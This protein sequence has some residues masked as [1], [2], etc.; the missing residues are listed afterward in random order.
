M[1]YL[2]PGGQH[3]EEPQA[4]S[5]VQ[6]PRP[7]LAP[8]LSRMVGR[9][10]GEPQYN[11]STESNSHSS[12]D[13]LAQNEMTVTVNDNIILINHT[14]VFFTAEKEQE[15]NINKTSFPYDPGGDSIVRMTEHM[16]PAI[17]KDYSLMSKLAGMENLHTYRDIRYTPYDR[18]KGAAKAM[19]LITS[20]YVGMEVDH[21]PDQVQGGVNGTASHKQMLGSQNKNIVLEDICEGLEGCTSY[22]QEV[23]AVY[24]NIV[25]AV[26]QQKR[27][28]TASDQEAPC[29]EEEWHESFED[30]QQAK[31]LDSHL[32]SLDL[33]TKRVL[34]MFVLTLNICS[35]QVWS[36]TYRTKPG[37]KLTMPYMDKKVVPSKPAGTSHVCLFPD[38]SGRSQHA[39]YTIMRDQDKSGQGYFK[40]A[41]PAV[42]PCLVFQMSGMINFSLLREYLFTEPNMDQFQFRLGN[43]RA[44]VGVGSVEL[45]LTKPWIDEYQILARYHTNTPCWAGNFTKPGVGTD[46]DF[47]IDI[48]LQLFMKA[49]L[50]PALTSRNI[51]CKKY[52]G[53]GNH[54]PCKITVTRQPTIWTFK[55]LS[56]VVVVYAD[57][58]SHWTRSGHNY[59]I[60]KKIFRSHAHLV[61]LLENKY[62]NRECIFLPDSGASC[63]NYLRTSAMIRSGLELESHLQGKPLLALGTLK[64][65][66]GAVLTWNQQKRLSPP[67][68]FGHPVAR[69]F[70]FLLI[71]STQS[72]IEDDLE[73]WLSTPPSAELRHQLHEY[74]GKIVAML[75]Y[76]RVILEAWEFILRKRVNGKEMLCL[77]NSVAAALADC[78]HDRVNCGDEQDMW[79]AGRLAAGGNIESLTREAPQPDSLQEPLHFRRAYGMVM[80]ELLTAQ[81][82]EEERDAQ[83][84]YWKSDIKVPLTLVETSQDTAPVPPAAW[85]SRVRKASCI[86]QEK[87]ISRDRERELRVKV[88]P[89]NAFSLSSKVKT[90]SLKS[91][92][93]F[94]TGGTS[95][96]NWPGRACRPR[97]IM[98]AVQTWSTW[99]TRAGVLKSYPSAVTD[100]E[101]SRFANFEVAVR[102]LGHVGPSFHE[103]SQGLEEHSRYLCWIKGTVRPSQIHQP[104]V[105][106]CSDKRELHLC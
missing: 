100:A 62:L 51:S 66:N 106:R 81:D 47:N 16:M 20:T 102:K 71:G 54:S 55:T 18:G 30:V 78:H 73:E 52:S 53:L 43:L 103:Y 1:R 17:L 8:L 60:M 77:C 15:P 9:I 42:L 97:M 37:D 40:Q 84:L 65:S 104:C 59:A 45:S 41:V 101:K 98:S 11:T 83:D 69:L 95:S 85:P 61:F 3:Q 36:N 80:R 33:Q 72:Y 44:N 24:S 50:F 86:L 48:D 34:V 14:K 5:T 92:A 79:F 29:N 58:V 87:S 13:T 25:I 46:K 10:S 7:P 64:T 99:A 70:S 21:I 32:G 38:H 94:L 26:S 39:T 57:L 2:D 68:A 74:D 93:G 96:S 49:E 28:S 82:A 12:Y 22:D 35:V 27:S 75:L 6:L 19:E 31:S 76:P 23:I 56:P 4:S 67:G 88:D 90:D 89:S 105:V 63:I 91:R